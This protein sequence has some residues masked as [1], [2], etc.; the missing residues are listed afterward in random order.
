MQTADT[1]MSADYREVSGASSVLRLPADRGGSH[2]SRSNTVRRS[3][4][5]VERLSW[6]ARTC[7]QS[8]RSVVSGATRAKVGSSTCSPGTRPSSPAIRPATTPGHT[9]VNAKGKFALHLVPAGIFYSDKTAIIGNGMVI[10]PPGPDRRDHHARNAAGVSTDRL[11]VS[12]RAHLVMPWHPI[13]D[14]Q[15]EQFRGKAAVGTTGK[16]VG[17]RIFRQG[18]PLG[19]PHVRT[20]PTPRASWARLRLVLDYK[21]EMLTRLYGVE[22]LDFDH[23]LPDLPRVLGSTCALR[24]RYILDLSRGPAPRRAHPAR[25]RAGLAARPR[26]RHL[27]LRDLLRPHLHGRRSGRRCG[28]RPARTSTG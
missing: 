8:W 19:H 9:I 26:R 2:S 14:Q 7:R 23:V 18:R 6:S 17:P 4:Q 13:I 25:R 16:G 12:D 11:K 5:E 22:P 20:G 24:H 15:E 1:L 10:D 27:R 28:H 21:N 3:P